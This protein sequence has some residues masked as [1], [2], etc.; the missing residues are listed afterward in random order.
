MAGVDHFTERSNIWAAH[1]DF[2]VFVVLARGRGE[3]LTSAGAEL[4]RHTSSWYEFPF[5]T[6]W[7][8]LVHE[9]FRRN[10]AR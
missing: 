7:D 6:E 1:V 2:C 3:W 5:L 9:Q 4:I 8:A 10:P